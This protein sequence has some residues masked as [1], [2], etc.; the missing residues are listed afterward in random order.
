MGTA[1]AVELAV[2]RFG[3][4]LNVDRRAF[5]LIAVANNITAAIAF[6]SLDVVRDP[7]YGES[8]SGLLP[9]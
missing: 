3:Y 2:H 7:I 6:I 1:L 5:W 9:N 4:R 8:S